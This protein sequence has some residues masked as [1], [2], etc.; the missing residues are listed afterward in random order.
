MKLSR[1][2]L[3]LFLAAL[4][5][6]GFNP[7]RAETS[8]RP[9]DQP[10]SPVREFSLTL[11]RK[12]SRPGNWD[13]V[14]RPSQPNHY[15]AT[16][17]GSDGDGGVFNS[18][19][20]EQQLD[21]LP[22]WLAWALLISVG[23][24]VTSLALILTM[25]LTIKKRTKSLRKSEDRY[26]RFFQTSKDSVFITTLDGQWLDV[27]QA[28][29]N[30]FGYS[31]RE[32][33]MQVPVREFYADPQDRRPHIQMIT[34]QGF[35]KDYPVQMKKKDGT[36]IDT[37]FTS[38][39]IKDD[40]DQVTGFQG[41]IRD[42][43]ERL[44]IQEELA[45]HRERFDL[46]IKGTDIGMWDWNVETGEIIIDERWAEI[47]GY[48]LEE[49]EPTTMETWEALC[50]PEDLER[51][52]QQIAE[53]FAGD[54][55]QYNIELRMQHK[56]G[57]WVWVLDRGK[58]VEW[59]E[60]G[61]PLRMAGT[62]Q[63]I[64]NRIEVEEELDQYIQKLENLYHV[65]TALT[66]SLSLDGVLS[67]IMDSITETIPYASATIFL[68]E[69]DHL[70]VVTARGIGED[71]IGSIFPIRSSLFREIRETRKSIIIDDARRDDRFEGWGGTQ[72]VRGWMGVPLQIKG[73]LIGYITFDSYQ[74]HAYGYPEA[75]LAE[76]F[77]AQAA[78]AIENARLYEQ[79]QEYAQ[80]LE[81]RVQERTSE[82]QE[83]V[84]LMAGRE[85]RMAELKETIQILR[86]QLENAGLEPAAD[87][88]LYEGYPGS[89]PE[90]K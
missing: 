84:N 40:Q 29:V 8:S 67:L 72:D 83:I 11:L 86:G 39:A 89:L 58:V 27:N 32:E 74:S 69:G 14:S 81:Q 12:I 48:S 30:L 35:V 24:A 21:I 19:L 42:V 20:V 54:R 80:E 65:T 88:P 37:L 75:E 60:D 59:A 36:I 13:P 63:D 57:S 47:A 53:H 28:T 25:R 68:V 49:L 50:H 52:Y 44:A 26:R 18:Y 2:F 77:A 62:H 73:E 61:S 71:L 15:R 46:A 64:T 31:D 76:P 79:T 16:S 17:P 38:A 5:F 3:L 4:A 85:I 6:S 1:T 56:D 55:D 34:D 70:R 87:D 33:F 22:P 45:A 43:T 7:V 41:T 10:T 9:K 82:L 66:S 23:V 90:Q 78:Q 51:S